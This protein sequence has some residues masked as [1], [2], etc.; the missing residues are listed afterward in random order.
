MGYFGLARCFS[1][2][3][4]HTL[5]GRYSDSV[6][7]EWDLRF[8]VFSEFPG[9]ASAAG[10]WLSDASPCLLCAAIVFPSS[11]KQ[12]VI[13]GLICSIRF[14]L[15]TW[16]RRPRIQGTSEGSPGHLYDLWVSA[17]LTSALT[18]LSCVYYNLGVFPGSLTLPSACRTEL[19][20][21]AQPAYLGPWNTV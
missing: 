15:V 8:C 21:N 18:T 16:P 1:E 13:L 7:L 5:L 20:L 6:G 17:L 3:N 12:G 19:V 9:E 10:S 14:S 11:Q 2:L 4:V